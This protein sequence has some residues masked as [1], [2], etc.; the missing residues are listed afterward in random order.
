MSLK[1]SSSD[2]IGIKISNN[3][4]NHS[5]SKQMYSFPKS[6]RFPSSLNL[7][8]SSTF[9]YYLPSVKS[10]R[11]TSLG[12]GTK[13][14]FTKEKDYNAPFYH[15]HRLF[16]YKNGPTYSFGTSKFKNEKDDCS[17]G[18]ANYNTIE[19]FGKD[20]PKYTFQKKY[21]FKNLNNYPGPG[22]YGNLNLKNGFLSKYHNFPFVSF[23]KASRMNDYKNNVPGPNAYKTENLINGGKI[24]FDS[25]FK[26]CLGRTIFAKY[27]SYFK[28]NDTP[29]PG[30]YESFS[31]FGIYGKKNKKKKKI[32]IR[33]NKSAQ[34]VRGGFN[35]NNE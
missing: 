18:P 27:G 29:G 12:Y 24:I 9:Y 14:D 17:P 30:A 23:T 5:I 33:K 28:I 7:N 3:Q 26:S 35:D 16:D 13:S 6:K 32:R 4:L 1:N 19:I 31:E 25:R 8:T 21:Y 2:I 11:S 34:D 20:A 15:L 10:N 22:Q